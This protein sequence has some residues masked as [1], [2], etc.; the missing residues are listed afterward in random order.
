MFKKKR[1]KKDKGDPSAIYRVHKELEY[2]GPLLDKALGELWIGVNIG[3]IGSV[4]ADKFRALARL[5]A[6]VKNVVSSYDK[7]ICEN[8]NISDKPP[9]GEELSKDD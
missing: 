6:E 3:G 4:S 9:D 2:L 5:T 1:K 8:L 7:V